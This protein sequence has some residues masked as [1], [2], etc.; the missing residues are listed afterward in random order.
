[1]KHFILIAISTL[2][3]SCAKEG[4][5]VPTSNNKEDFLVTLLFVVNGCSVYRFNDSGRNNYFSDCRGSIDHT[6]QTCTGKNNC[7]THHHKT[8]NE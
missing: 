7:S 3:F 8:I 4:T 5:P 2:V 6:T 1:M